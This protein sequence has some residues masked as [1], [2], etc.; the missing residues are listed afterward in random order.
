MKKD[1]KSS[2]TYWS[3]Y[4]AD[5]DTIAGLPKTT[6]HRNG[7]YL[8][9]EFAFFLKGSLR[10][11]VR[12]LCAELGITENTFIQTAWGILLGRYNNTSDVVFGSVVSGRPGELEGIEDMIGLFINAIPVRIQV[13]ED[14]TIRELLREVQQASIAGMEHHYI[15]LA[16]IQSASELG[17]DLFDHMVVFENYPVKEMVEQNI[18]DSTR[19]KGLSFLSAEVFEQSNYDFSIMVVSDEDIC[20]RFRFNANVYDNGQMERLQQHLTRL[21]DKVLEDPSEF[22]F[23]IDFLSPEEKQQLL[24]DFNDTGLDYP[25]DMTLSSLFEEQVSRTPD[26]IAL[27]YENRTFSY[28]ELN[29]RADRLAQ[30]QHTPDVRRLRRHAQLLSR[31][32]ESRP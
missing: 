12:N 30:G 19:S 27:V 17:R 25:A 8:D 7:A 22:A 11:S 32:D 14:G 28:K 21:I 13:R 16:E 3:N 5:Y 9:R 10:Q 29:E 26:A 31:A 18:T 6:S 23:N 15:Q 24:T 20:I 2:L 4:L 1:W